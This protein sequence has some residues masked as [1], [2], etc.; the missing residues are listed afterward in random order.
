[1]FECVYK[2]HVGSNCL[3]LEVRHF[4]AVCFIWV[5]GCQVLRA[6]IRGLDNFHSRNVHLII[7]KVSSPTD[8]QDNCFKRS[9]KIYIKLAPTC[10]G[11][12]TIIRER[13]I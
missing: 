13:T 2:C 11:V 12:I 6:Q 7:I 4:I 8:A 9:I 3:C 1:M 5:I 10:F